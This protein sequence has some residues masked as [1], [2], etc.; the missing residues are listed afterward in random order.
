[1]EVTIDREE[2]STVFGRVVLSPEDLA[3]SEQARKALFEDIVRNTFSR[4]IFKKEAEYK[5][6]QVQAVALQEEV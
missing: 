2:G 3:L 4:F 1:M 5:A 6:K